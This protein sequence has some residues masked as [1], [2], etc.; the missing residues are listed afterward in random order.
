MD[1]FRRADWIYADR[2]MAV[3]R[4][5]ALLNIAAVIW[6]IATS[7]GGVD[8]NGF[9]LG[10]DFLSFWTT[11][12]ML[13]AGGNP[14]DVA[15]HIAEQRTFFISESG[16]T[17][18]FYPPTFLPFLLPLGWL[19]Y[20]PALALWLSATGALFV[21]TVRAWWRRFDCQG[22]FW[23]VVLAFPGE[24]ICI[25]HGQTS[26]L[27][28]ALLGAGTLLVDR[29]PWLA[30]FLI[31]LATI[32]PQFG[33]LIPFVLLATGQWRVI[34]GAVIGAALLALAATL[35]A[36]AGVW[37]AW[38]AIGDIA[39]SSM[40][41]G[42]IGFAKMQSP[43]AAIRLLGGSVE[44][45]YA[46]QAV[47]SLAV[48]GALVLAGRRNGWSLGLGATMLAGTLVA[49]PFVLDY[50]MVLS[51][52]PLIYLAGTGFRPWEKFIAAMIFIVPLFGRIIGLHLGVPLAAPMLLIFFALL[53][54]RQF[55][56]E[57]PNPTQ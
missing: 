39:N 56:P 22:Q 42:Q 4:V 51:A 9:L 40:I 41:N 33:I 13:V 11:A 34:G 21:L 35:V 52:F 5:L 20:F 50:D 28:A 12:H 27:L 55:S 31:G 36:G 32:K 37:Q 15:A 43:F 2:A 45:A 53:V 46:V 8:A 54:R 16:F 18:F 6:M 47:M 25:T 38:L 7:T 10:T 44:L 49:T 29:R 24:W 30:G 14:Y 3:L 19:G 57:D 1:F 26:F 17:A 23:L 48:L